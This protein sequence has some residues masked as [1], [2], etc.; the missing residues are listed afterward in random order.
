MVAGDAV[1]AASR[2]QATALAGQVWVDDATRALTVAAISYADAGTHQLKGKAEPVRLHVAQAVVAA[3]GGAQ[4]VDGL[5]APHT[6]RERELRMLKELFHATEESGR[7]RLV[8][9]EA[10]VGVG[11]SRLGWE[12]EKYIDGLLS[13]VLWH[14]G[15]CLSYGDGVAFWALAEAVR[16]RLGLVEA[17]AGPVVLERLEQGLDEY[18]TDVDERIWLRPRLAA[19][20]G[21][22]PPDGLVRQELF[23]AWTTF[24]ERVGGGSPVVLVVDDAQHADDGLVDFLDHL[25]A[26]ARSGVYV[27]ALARP[28][29]L[30]RRPDLAAR[31]TV[32]H[33]DPLD[34]DAMSTLLDGLVDDLPAQVRDALV[35]RA[36][37]VPLFAVETVRSLIDQD[38][39]V[40][41]EGRY[42]LAVGAPPDLAALSAP[43]TLQAVVAARLDALEPS[44]RRV[45][46]GGSV[47]GLSFT[48]DAVGA[49]FPDQD[50]D[51]TLSALLRKQILS[52]QTDR[53]SAERGQYR[54][55][56]TVV[57]QVAY[58]T[59][60]RRDRKARHLAVVQ[61]LEAQL[62]PGDELSAV[63]AQHLID[64]AEAEPDDSDVAELNA[65]ATELLERAAR[66]AH[67]L[68]A[69]G[70]ALRLLRLA[71]ART[72]DDAVCH[73]LQVSAARAALDSGDFEAAIELGA[74]AAAGFD[75][76]GDRASAAT[77]A[78][79][80][81]RAM[82]LYGDN[83]AAIAV[84]LPRWQSL[85]DTSDADAARLKLASELSASYARLGDLE[86]GREFAHHHV[87][88]AERLGDLS[89]LAHALC[90]LGIEYSGIG[91]VRTGTVLMTG[92]TELARRERLL[93]PLVR[94]LMN[95]G[96][97]LLLTDLPACVETMREA[98]QL[99][100][101]LGQRTWQA[102]SATNFI[103]AL[104]T[105]GEW[106]EMSGVLRD[107]G[108]ALG[109]PGTL[110]SSTAAHA[111]YGEARALPVPDMPELPDTDTIDEVGWAELS[112]ML[113]K[114]AAGDMAAAAASGERAVEAAMRW[115]DIGDDFVHVWPPAVQVCIE[116]GDLDRAD[117]LIGLVR[118][119]R[120]STV[121]PLLVAHLQYAEGLLAAARDDLTEAEVQLGLAVAGFGSF[122][123]V[124]ARARAQE[125]LGRVLLDSGRP[126]EGRQLLDA[127]VATY[128]SLGADGWLRMLEPVD[129]DRAVPGAL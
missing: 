71:I 48:R 93:E 13:S 17:D 73:R 114:R 84:L 41:R 119:R 19:L 94:S 58:D 39:V 68:G 78:A 70:E 81:A 31:A 44:E 28:G 10:D 97:E 82:R 11:K 23:T 122:G 127:A 125:R 98:T 103:Y 111:L 85:P 20:V 87:L 2:V 83:A 77:A 76:L 107:F 115:A 4:R 112:H 86:A 22:G 95:L 7:P 128:R 120:T 29:L 105:A 110:G 46:A 35:L 63:I 9:V 99:S 123:A 100:L 106:D 88:I 80:Q 113:A 8:L 40:P 91:A 27:L 38:L 16:G 55:V 109:D 32:L 50:V 47:L 15:R 121:P 90:T 65:R 72:R 57:R 18:V 96:T 33:L 51:R 60:S 6:G 101:Q 49:L 129:A 54:F 56:Q 117:R 53:L 124:P 42:A 116:A 21:A 61:H 69:P 36:E 37:G 74:A 92:A 126:E 118:S 26:T 5:E 64:A 62:D 14:R 30:E 52:L 102:F 24:L 12:F 79:A 75:T 25:L 66:R 59:L 43:A 104:W 67:G 45:V 89:E 108:E 34:D 1:N 3:R